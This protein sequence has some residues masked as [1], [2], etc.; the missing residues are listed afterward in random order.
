MYIILIQSAFKV[1]RGISKKAAVLE[2][3]KMDCDSPVIFEA[4]VIEEQ[5]SYVYAQECS[6]DKEDHLEHLRAFY[7]EIPFLK[8]WY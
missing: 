2:P 8:G 6:V 3:W 4:V 1:A 7:S 5:G